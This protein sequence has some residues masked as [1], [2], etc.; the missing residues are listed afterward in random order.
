MKLPDHFIINGQ[1]FYIFFI[2]KSGVSELADHL[3]CELN[4]VF[5]VLYHCV[6]LVEENTKYL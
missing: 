1:S 3:L 5:L 2:F 4:P 6:E